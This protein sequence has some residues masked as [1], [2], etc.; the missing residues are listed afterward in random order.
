MYSFLG[1]LS[2]RVQ[3]RVKSNYCLGRVKSNNSYRCYSV[4]VRGKRIS[5]GK[6]SLS[7][8]IKSRRCI[9]SVNLPRWV[10]TSRVIMSVINATRWLA[11]LFS[12]GALVFPNYLASSSGGDCVLSISLLCFPCVFPI[13]NLKVQRMKLLLTSVGVYCIYMFLCFA[14]SSNR[15][16]SHLIVSNTSL[17]SALRP[18]VRVFYLFVV[19]P[20]SES[21]PG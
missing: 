12:L 21:P 10:A 18:S 19:Y 20:F 4:F 6:S 15:L 7:P 8:G 14:L 13:A 17:R 16:S 1:F 2:G 11:L 9:M 3:H 5:P